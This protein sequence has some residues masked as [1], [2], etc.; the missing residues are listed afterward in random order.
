[1]RGK[2]EESLISPHISPRDA[3]TARI[4]QC[5]GEVIAELP[6][7]QEMEEQM[8][9]SDKAAAYTDDGYSP[10]LLDPSYRVGLLSKNIILLSRPTNFRK[11]NYLMV[12]AT[13]ANESL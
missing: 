12:L 7:L 13:G 3:V 2:Q 10:P 9:R 8:A 1:M 6:F 11:L 4:R 5:G